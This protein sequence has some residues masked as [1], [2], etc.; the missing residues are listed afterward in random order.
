MS[1]TEA[2]AAHV[3]VSRGGELM[4]RWQE[5]FPDCVAVRSLETA[6]FQGAVVVWLHLVPGI[7]AGPQVAGL[8]AQL[9]R[10]RI[11]ALSDLPGDEEALAAFA[12][13]ARGYCNSH[14]ATLLL[15]RIAD[16][17]AQ[18]GLWIGPS[19]MQRLL[20]GVA[21]LPALGAE[22]QAPVPLTPRELEAAALMARGA[23]QVEMAAELGVTGRTVKS[24]TAAVMTKLGVSD[25]LQL[26]L[27]LNRRAAG[28]PGG[29]G[30]LR[31][32]IPP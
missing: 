14:A 26:A 24:R 10:A 32:E 12:A 11:V 9:S 4:P 16:T 7:K 6:R 8:A 1:K 31:R 25:R 19:L 22:V 17:V 23:S 30:A 15:R 28:L 29:Q 2:H 27:V 5:A 20:R 18:G 3:F 13:G 21:K